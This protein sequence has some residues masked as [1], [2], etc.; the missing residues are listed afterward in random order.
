MILSRAHVELEGQGYMYSRWLRWAAGGW[1]RAVSWTVPDRCAVLGLARAEYRGRIPKI[2]KPLRAYKLLRCLTVR[3]RE[4]RWRLTG[5]LPNAYLVTLYSIAR[6]E[7]LSRVP[8]DR[9]I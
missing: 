8:G 9:S 5:W 4:T 7:L 3:A 2:S 1:N 6:A